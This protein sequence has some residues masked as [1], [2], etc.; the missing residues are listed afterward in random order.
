MSKQSLKQFALQQHVPILK[1]DAQNFL[2]QLVLKE[3]K[4]DILEL[5]TAI[6]YTSIALA[7]LNKDI[8]IDTLEKDVKM[9][10]QARKNISEAKLENQINALALDIDDFVP[11]KKY[12]VIFVDAAKAQY[13]KYFLNFSPYLKEDGFFFFDNMLFHHMVMQKE[14]IFNPGTRRLVAKIREFRQNVCLNN[15]YQ[16]QFYDNIGDGIL[17]MRRRLK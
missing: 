16:A 12:D 4:R 11:D 8:H 13:Q 15:N 9:V 14:K 3:N 1:D 2:C 5:G 17:V 10:I 7:S 6:G